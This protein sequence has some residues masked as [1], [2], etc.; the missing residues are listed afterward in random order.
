[1]KNLHYLLSAILFSWLICFSAS[2]QN[3]LEGTVKNWSN[4]DGFVAFY[5]MLSGEMSRLGTINSQGNLH[6]PL[7]A[8]YLNTVNLMSKKA[9]EKAPKGWEI[10]H[11]T[12]SSA[13]SCIEEDKITID[14]GETL[15]A[16]LPELSLTDKGGQAD[17]GILYAVSTPEIA[18]WLFSYG[19][20]NISKGYY[21]KWIFTEKPAGVNGICAIPTYTG[22]G[23]EMYDDIL[24][25][26]LKLDKGWNVIKYDIVETFTSQNGKVYPSKTEVTKLENLPEN[27]LWQVIQN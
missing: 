23:E 5:D 8:D 24:Q 21:L 14:S 11:N 3:S 20:E 26:N 13:F 4:G 16:G 1:M 6:I 7:D 19:E 25:M 10:R 9:A 22:N 17:F 18:Q 15:L 27:L 12:V 2:A